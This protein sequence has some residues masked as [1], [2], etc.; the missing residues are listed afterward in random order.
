ME[1][2]QPQARDRV[3][4]AFVDGLNEP[5]IL[6][7]SDH[8]IIALNDQALSL[9]S[10]SD[11]ASFF[12][13]D[14]GKLFSHQEKGWP[15]QICE[16]T[17]EVVRTPS[18][19]DIAVEVSLSELEIDNQY[20]LLGI[21]R[22]LREINELRESLKDA[23]TRLGNM[24]GNLPVTLF[25]ME[26][27]DNKGLAFP[28]VSAGV[29]G[30]LEVDGQDLATEP[31]YILSMLPLSARKTLLRQIKV[32]MET[33]QPLDEEVCLHVP[34]GYKLWVRFF[35][36]LRRVE[37]GVSV[38]DGAV[39]DITGQ[40][41][42]DERLRY[43]AYHDEDTLLPNRLGLE[44]HL[45]D[46]YSQEN[47]ESFALLTLA[48]DR[49]DLVNDTLGS[50]TATRLVVTV[51]QQLAG[52][53]EGYDAFLSHPRPENF[54]IVLQSVKSDKDV[55]ELAGEIL[56]TM[57]I[58]FEVGTRC[59]DVSVSMG[60]SISYKDGDNVETLIMNADTALRLAHKTSP[61]GYR[62]FVEEMNT[63]SLRV[64][65]YEN[66]L[67]KAISRK[68]FVTYFQPLVDVQ[69]GVLAGMEAL[70]RWRHPRLGLVGP[71]EFIPVA[72]EAGLIGEICH[73]VLYQTCKTAKMW[74][75]K[76]HKPIPLAVNI[77]W[78]QFAQPERLM[79]LMDEVFKETGLPPEMVELEL[80]ES[81][82]MEQPDSAIKTLDDLREFGVLASIDDFGTGYSSLSY[83]KKL[84]I[85]KLKIDRAFIL[86]VTE[87]KRDAAIVDAIIMLARAL[88]LKTVA[89]GIETAE[90]Y[91]FLR[92]RGCDLAQGFYFSRPV[93]AEEMEKMIIK[94]VISPS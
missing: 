30:L 14:I 4:E 7:D 17:E 22:D 93:P 59:L 72:E 63:R 87:N 69:T 78:R 90:Q 32:S 35:A 39:I 88:D 67:R 43:L 61:G 74:L 82:V 53:L 83:L 15:L 71:N 10:Y 58:P 79:M 46:L 3:F 52:V 60:I 80:T 5:A 1:L 16:K 51:S 86:E 62:F 84:P 40:H 44:D 77:S 23:N 92:E 56:K 89:E 38:W 41:L 11:R 18:G 81:S 65:A 75:D 8:E 49:L 94:G 27:R 85:S 36:N 42:L 47:G 33:G 91:A 26:L 24:L 20:C 2:L 50:E 57:K 66:R 13:R 70:V 9:L 12:S 45:N 31:D 19:V 55:A 37:E 76:G 25:E 21:F 28:F 34:Q 6:T 73:Q 29:G 68:E 64:L 54:S 48:I